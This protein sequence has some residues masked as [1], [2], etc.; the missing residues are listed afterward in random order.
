MDEW[1]EET[2]RSK[3]GKAAWL[4]CWLGNA[5][6]G[7]LAVLS[8][9]GL[10]VLIIVGAIK[11]TISVVAAIGLSIVG[12]PIVGTVAYWLALLIG[13]P[14]LGIA[15]LLDRDAVSEWVDSRPIDDY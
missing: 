12:V 4:L 5:I 11:G 2:P 7:V 6:T 9:L 8:G 3:R 15:K 14:L 13:M 10:T 1:D